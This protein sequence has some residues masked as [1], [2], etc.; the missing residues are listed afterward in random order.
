MKLL[1]DV[2]RTMKKKK[3]VTTKS[4]CDGLV[5]L[6]LPTPPPNHRTCNEP[7]GYSLPVDISLP[8]LHTIP[9]PKQPSSR[10]ELRVTSS[11]TISAVEND[12]VPLSPKMVKVLGADGREEEKM[13][14]YVK[15]QKK[16]VGGRPWLPLDSDISD[17]FLNVSPRRD[18]TSAHVHTPQS[19]FANRRGCNSS[20][21]VMHFENPG[22]ANGSANRSAASANRSSASAN[23]SVT[24]TNRSVANVF[25]A[26]GLCPHDHL[27]S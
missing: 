7:E 2:V 20:A 14:S 9:R 17:H 10:G 18:S 12:G 25:R 15:S 4:N 27:I 16:A 5:W 1:D 11:Q 13:V 21:F 3:K 19:P 6:P 24:P 23:R 26:Q 22:V 8:P